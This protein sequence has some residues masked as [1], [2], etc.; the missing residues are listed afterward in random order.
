M[1]AAGLLARLP[2]RHDRG[3]AYGARSTVEGRASGG[4]DG[5]CG[6][7][8]SRSR[9]RP[10]AGASRA[11][12]CR[13]PMRRGRRPGAAASAWPRVNFKL[14]LPFLP[15]L[16]IHPGLPSQGS[17]GAKP[18]LGGVRGAPAARA[19]VHPESPPLPATRQSSMDRRGR[20]WSPDDSRRRSPAL[21]SSAA[22]AFMRENGAPAGSTLRGFRPLRRRQRADAAELTE[23]GWNLRALL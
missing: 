6:G 2:E 4:R 13:R 19:R 16:F 15:L 18:L 22:A 7:R 3:A 23:S 9:T 10:W 1:R 8:E 21:A 14:H 20:A 5:G 17:S 11:R 12:R